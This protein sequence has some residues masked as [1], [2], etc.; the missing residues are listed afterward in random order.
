MITNLCYIS[1]SAHGRD[2]VA[3]LESVITDFR[4][5]VGL[6]WV[7]D[8]RRNAPTASGWSDIHPDNLGRRGAGNDKLEVA[9][10]KIILG[11]GIGA[12][13]AREERHKG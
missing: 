6:V 3:I 5:G 10:D 13:G 2:S 8:G 9:A 1:A 7:S 11:R 12:E 4:H